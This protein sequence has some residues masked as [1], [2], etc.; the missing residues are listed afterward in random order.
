MFTNWSRSTLFRNLIISRYRSFPY[1]MKCHIIIKKQTFLFLRE[2]NSISLIVQ[3]SVLLLKSDFRSCELVFPRRFLLH[4]VVESSP[5]ELDVPGLFTGT[6]HSVDICGC[7]S[8]S[9][10]VAERLCLFAGK[11]KWIIW[12]CKCHSQNSPPGGTRLS[13]F[14]NKLQT[15]RF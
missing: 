2:H 12:G 8:F 13:W 6:G 4:R 3:E 1:P 14:K 11:T 9:N 5:G 10:H 7:K 15:Y